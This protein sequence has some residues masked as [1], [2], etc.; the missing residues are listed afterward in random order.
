[1][2]HRGSTNKKILMIRSLAYSDEFKEAAEIADEVQWS[3][4]KDVKL[5]SQISEIYERCKRYSDAKNVLLFAYN[6]SDADKRTVYKLSELSAQAGDI[7]DA[8]KYYWK[9]RDMAPKDKDNLLLAYHIMCARKD[10]DEKKKEVL[11]LFLEGDFDDKWAYTLAKLYYKMGQQEKC[12][13]LCDEII[14]W[15]SGGNYGKPALHLKHKCLGID[16]DINAIMSGNE[17][18]QTLSEK[19]EASDNDFF[20]DSIQNAEGSDTDDAEE[21]IKNAEAVNTDDAEAVIQNAEASDTDDAGKV[22][23]NAEAVNTDDAEEVIKNAEAVNTDDA[24]AD[25]Q[26]AKAEAVNTDVTGTVLSQKEYEENTDA[27][28]E[29]LPESEAVITADESVEDTSE[30]K[31][32]PEQAPEKTL[33]NPLEDKPVSEGDILTVIAE[34][35]KEAAAA[36]ENSD[37]KEAAE[38]RVKLLGYFDEKNKFTPVNGQGRPTFIFKPEAAKETASDKTTAVSHKNPKKKSSR[39]PVVK[40]NERLFEVYLI[41][42]SN[43]KGAVKYAAG[44]LANINTNLGSRNAGAARISDNKFSERG[45]LKTISVLKGRDLVVDGVTGVNYETVHEM[46]DLIDA[47]TIAAKIA[48]VDTPTKLA[49]FVN[50]H[51]NFSEKCKYIYEDAAITKEEFMGYI[52][53]YAF[54]Q[55]AV[56]DDTAEDELD[57]IAEEM[58]DDGIPFTISDA[59]LLVDRAVERAQKAGVKKLFEASRNAEGYLILRSRHFY[60]G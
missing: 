14:L 58:I 19:S 52:S 21:V 53:N 6:R 41:E 18:G 3:K 55:N 9:F 2:M 36:S 39:K 37:I 34:Q 40:N 48:L 15:Y 16:D 17:A 47:K 8:E 22:I 27:G 56:L 32:K 44:K 26:N 60:R 42:C 29:I 33:D 57:D 54:K 25:M 10:T 59:A 31:Q 5:L 46:S 45:V 49:L 30:K 23:K 24:E 4:V 20:D 1:M 38:P 35:M 11:E 28:K 51:K 7:D 43:M 13:K 50:R 12:V